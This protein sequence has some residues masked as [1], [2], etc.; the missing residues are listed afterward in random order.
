MYAGAIYLTG[1][2]YTSL[3]IGRENQGVT[4]DGETAAIGVLFDGNTAGKSGGAVFGQM[5]NSINIYGGVTFKNNVAT[6]N[7]GGAINT[8]GAIIIEDAVFEGN[9]A[10][11]KGGA[12]YAYYSNKDLTTRQVEIKSGTFKNNQASKGGAVAFSA[13]SVDFPRGSIGLINDVTFEGNSAYATETDDPELPGGG[14]DDEDTAAQGKN[15]NGN[16]GAIYISRKSNVTIS[17]NT[18]F[19]SNAS[20]RNGGAI[21]VT[22]KANLS[23]I[24]SDGVTVLFDGNSAAGNGGAIYAHGEGT[25]FNVMAPAKTGDGTET[26]EKSV[27]FKNN[28][29]A[30]KGGAIYATN[31][32]E[33]L[34]D[35][36]TGVYINVNNSKFEANTSG[37][38]GGAV[39]CYTD[40]RFSIAGSEFVSNVTNSNAN[41]GGAVYVTASNGSISDTVFKTNTATYQNGGAIGIYSES[42]VQITRCEF[43]GNYTQAA[44]ANGGGAMYVSG[45][46]VTVTDSKFT[47]N[48]SKKNGGA[49]GIYSG[50]NV[51]FNGENQFTSNSADGSG[52]AIFVTTADTVVEFDGD[53]AFTLNTAGSNGGAVQAYG[54][55]NI[56]FKG[57]AEFTSNSATGNGG[58]IYASSS[59]TAMTFNGAVKFERNAANN[60]GAAYV[61]G[62][63]TV[64]FNEVIASQ[65]EAKTKGGFLYYTT[66]NT[67][68]TINSGSATENTAADGGS[69]IWSNTDKAKIR[70]KGTAENTLFKVNGDNV[71]YNGDSIS[72]KNNKIAIEYFEDVQT[73]E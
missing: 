63:S 11:S 24:Y 52:G 35:P 40:V 23:V 44:D 10:A 16:G 29:A 19:V 54:G 6:Q 55:S 48:T 15:F 5:K 32:S 73:N 51:R 67:V 45:S 7:N 27:V 60:G 26:L 50:A 4:S 57:N 43:N 36:T 59:G 41:G 64:T 13:S 65:N 69:A 3:H 49:I 72:G 1:S 25:V 37:E 34:Q 9:R 58:A 39:Y 68:V 22:G 30:L 56:T 21:Y 8:S 62:P 31:G 18:R 42:D 61:T 33:R 53:S 20:E 71:A 17:G 28:N 12:I 66:T 47:G 70:V 38:N 46:T 2:Q 14:E